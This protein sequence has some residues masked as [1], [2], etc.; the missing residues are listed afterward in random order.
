MLTAFNKCSVNF[1]VFIID[2]KWG[3]GG[4]TSKLGFNA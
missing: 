3:F 2:L 1:M 4:L